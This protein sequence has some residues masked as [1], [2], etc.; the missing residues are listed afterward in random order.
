MAEVEQL[1]K[2]KWKLKFQ[3]VILETRRMAEKFGVPDGI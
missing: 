3:R 1:K 2:L